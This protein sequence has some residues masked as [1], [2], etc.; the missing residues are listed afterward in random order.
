[1]ARKEGGDPLE[2]VALLSGM[3]HFPPGMPE[4]ARPVHERLPAGSALCSSDVGVL[5]D[6]IDTEGGL[7]GLYKHLAHTKE[8]PLHL[9]PSITH[10]A[11]CALNG[12][13]VPLVVKSSLGNA[14]PRP[15]VYLD[16]RGG[17]RER[18][19]YCK[20]CPRCNVKHNMP[21]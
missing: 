9:V 16:G 4:R 7:G 11:V 21:D 18:V 5:I 17:V 13:Q 14:F 8:G 15:T 6:R 10:C 12:E 19:L 3:H 2:G 1:M 20:W